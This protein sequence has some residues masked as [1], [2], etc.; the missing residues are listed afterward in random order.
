MMMQ[1]LY[2][3]DLSSRRELLNIFNLMRRKVLICFRN[4][5]EAMRRRL[6]DHD[7]LQRRPTVGKLRHKSKHAVAPLVTA[8][9]DPLLLMQVA[10]VGGGGELMES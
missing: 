7:A 5:D 2:T 6:D 9:A 10:F 1:L 3:L 8:A 4:F